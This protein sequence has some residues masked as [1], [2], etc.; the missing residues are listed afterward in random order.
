MTI[1]YVFRREDGAFS[2]SGTV[3]Y[4]DETYGSTETA[5]PPHDPETAAAVWNGESWSVTAL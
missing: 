5:P 4:D 3:H 1:W 2:G